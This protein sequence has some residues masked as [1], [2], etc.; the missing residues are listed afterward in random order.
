METRANFV[1]LGAAAIIGAAFL[2][3]FSAWLIGSDWRSGYHVYEVVFQGPVRGLSEGG[4]VRFNG[5]KVGEVKNLRLDEEDS[6]R[7]IARVQINA[8]TPVRANTRARLEAIGLTGVNLIQLDAGSS[9]QPPLR[10][11]MGQPAPRIYAVPGTIE[12]LLTDEN[13]ERILNTL[14]NLERI[15]E[16]LAQDDSVI[17]ESA[18]AA[19][20]IS[21][22]ARAVATLSEESRTS[23]TGLSSS[24]QELLVEARTAIEN[25]NGAIARFSSAAESA[26]N[27]TLPELTEAAQDLRRLSRAIERLAGE[28]EDNPTGFIAGRTQPTIQVPQ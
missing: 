23:I 12:G 14:R 17:A 18:T 2:M 5:I 24:T 8:R 27:E 21:E 1:L 10:P 26:E 15:S 11:R 3:L 28:V 22:A 4:E 9:D 13:A 7:V 25:A 6:T 16:Q 19:R 20:Y